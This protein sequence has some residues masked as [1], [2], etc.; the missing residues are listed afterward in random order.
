MHCGLPNQFFLVGGMIH[1]TDPA[2]PLMFPASAVAPERI[3]KWGTRPHGFLSCPST[4]LA[5]LVQLVVLVSAFVMVSFLFAVLLLM[6]A[7]FAQPFVKVGARAP[8][9]WSRRHWASGW[10]TYKTQY[11]THPAPPPPTKQ[12]DDPKKQIMGNAVLMIFQYRWCHFDVFFFYF[13][14]CYLPGDAV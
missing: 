1:P 11:F 3:W 14:G 12:L 5:L 9:L 7:P 13:I 6:V 4:F 2:A 10:P 8:C